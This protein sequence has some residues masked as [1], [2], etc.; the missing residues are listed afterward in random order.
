MGS[1]GVYFL[2][3]VTAS[4]FYVGWI[5]FSP[6][7]RLSCSSASYP[8]AGGTYRALPDLCPDLANAGGH[9][10]LCQS[11][12]VVLARQGRGAMGRRVASRFPPMGRVYS[13][14]AVCELA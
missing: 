14:D 2:L 13:A 12:R 3:G 8:A 5:F 6:I 7:R 4:W 1:S 11:L 9:S 10:S